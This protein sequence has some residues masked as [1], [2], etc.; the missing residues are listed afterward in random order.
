M[1]THN[2]RCYRGRF[3]PSPTG[4]LHFG[5]LIAAMGSFLDTRARNG[6]WLV[7]I[8]DL[9]PPREVPGAAQEIVDTLLAFGMQPDGDIVYQSQRA[10]L[11]EQA[12]QQ[13]ETL[14][15]CFPCACSRRD[16]REMATTGGLPG[17]YP[18]TCRDGLPPG[19]TAR[20][21]RLRVPDREIRF[22]D[23]LQGEIREHL[24]TSCGDFVLKRADGL[25]AYQ[26][27]VVVDDALQGI[28]HVVRG[29][30]LLDST[31]RQ[32]LLQ[33]LLG[34]SVPEYLHLPV[35]ANRMGEK[36]SKQTL[37]VPIDAARAVPTLCE[38]ARFLGQ[39]PPDSLRK[40]ATG[41]FWDWA[42]AGWNPGRLPRQRLIKQH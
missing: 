7:R 21:I 23:R 35:A 40:A 11:Y 1:T 28:T 22:L 37:A 13:L 8:E 6:E 18:G 20:A 2:H 30:D 16:I 14:G 29:A 33:E 17:I 9:D 12:L 19:R 27:A 36:L 42:I 38:A 10:A 34:Y 41:D 31:A 25:F 3:A 39:S 5:S 24:P 15:H 4:P 26:L 32:I